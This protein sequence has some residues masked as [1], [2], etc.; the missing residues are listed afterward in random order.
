MKIATTSGNE[1]TYS[2]LVIYHRLVR[3]ASEIYININQFAFFHSGTLSSEPSKRNCT[4]EVTSITI[5]KTVT[6]STDRAF[7]GLHSHNLGAFITKA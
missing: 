7:I 2:K 5:N 6:S 1:T 4:N 3:F